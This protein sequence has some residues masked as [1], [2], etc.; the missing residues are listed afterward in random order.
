MGQLLRS[1]VFVLAVTAALP[2]AALAAASSLTL[3]EQIGLQGRNA[4][5][6]SSSADLTRQGF[7]AHSASST[8][9]WTLCDGRRATSRCQ[10]VNGR[11][12]VLKLKPRIVRP[13]LNALALY[14]RAGLKG[15]RV[16]YSFPAE[17]PPGFRP[18]SAR[19]WGGPWSVCAGRT[20]GCETIEG[21]RANLDMD[22]VLVRPGG[23]AVL[24]HKHPKR[25]HVSSPKAATG[26]PRPSLT[27]VSIRRGSAFPP[28]R[29]R[30]TAAPFHAAH[31]V[32]RRDRHRTLILSRAP[33]PA[34]GGS[35]SRRRHG[36]GPLAVARFFHWRRAPHRR[37]APTFEARHPR[38][39]AERRRL[40]H[41][42][43][44]AR[45][46]PEMDDGEDW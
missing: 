30:R 10:T 31:Q 11:A 40:Y 21:R 33:A 29:I 46:D 19:T 26:R 34:Q 8:G 42:I 37:S 7:V 25:V 39:H 14:E 41:R 2:A 28:K 5:Y 24:A 18:H 36:L 4:T 1:L 3:Y 43:R 23:A 45:R 17:K 35:Q 20:G 32:G 9:M 12:A 38:E 13:G 6:R 22:V 16:I 15:R 44:Y 27:P